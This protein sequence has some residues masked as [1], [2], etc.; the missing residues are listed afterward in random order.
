MTVE[1]CFCVFLQHRKPS[2]STRVIYLLAGILSILRSTMMFYI[3]QCSSITIKSDA[4][5]GS[6][7]VSVRFKKGRH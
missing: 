3:R 2:A 1:P 5:A 4:Y 7:T 6:F